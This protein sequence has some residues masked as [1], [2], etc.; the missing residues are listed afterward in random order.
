MRGKVRNCEWRENGGDHAAAEQSAGIMSKVAALQKQVDFHQKSHPDQRRVLHNI[1]M[2]RNIMELWDA[3]DK[4]FNKIDSQTL[5][6]GEPL[7]EGMYHL[8]C[9]IAVRHTDGT[10]L[11]MQ[12]DRNKHYGGMWELTAGGSALQGETASECAAR[13]LAEETGIRAADLTELGTAVNDQNHTLYTEYLCRTNCQKDA[14]I[15]RQGETIQY[16]WVTKQ[17]LK[18][19][20]QKLAATRIL[21]Y[22][23]ELQD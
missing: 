11:L 12:R 5:V 3:Y 17:K 20:Y 9:Q 4:G 18:E 22:L 8:V 21:R 19:M 16:Q 15:L 14:I 13:E 10:Y 2:R 23:P 6:R 7:P 1:Q